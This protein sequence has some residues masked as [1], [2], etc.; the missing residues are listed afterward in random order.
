VKW[1]L[2]TGVAAF[3]AGELWN[4]W[5]PINKNLWTSSFVLLTGGF[6]LVVLASFYWIIEMKNLRGWW[7]MPILVFGMNS[8]AGFVADSVVWGPG[9]AFHLKTAD[10]M[11]VPWHEAFYVR[12]LSVVPNPQVASLLYSICAVLFCWSLLWFLWRSKIFLKI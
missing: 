10:G 3:A 7:T 4:R 12:F 11:L 6:A 2:I 5:F 1:L 8:I 9:Y